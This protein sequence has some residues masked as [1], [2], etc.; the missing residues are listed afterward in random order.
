MI[1]IY[2]NNIENV[3]PSQSPP[4]QPPPSQSPPSQSSPSQSPPSQSP[5]SQPP[6]SQPPP[7]Q[8]PPLQSPPHSTSSDIQ[9]STIQTD[10]PTYFTHILSKE[11]ETDLSS[12]KRRLQSIISDLQITVDQC[13][14]VSTLQ[15][16]RTHLQSAATMGRAM[17]EH[18]S[19]TSLGVKRKIAS[20]K[21]QEKQLHFFST[22]KR[23]VCGT[24]GLSKPSLAE[25]SAQ[26][27]KLKKQE[28]KFCGVCLKENDTNSGIIDWIQCYVCTVWI[29]TSCSE[30]DTSTQDYVCQFCQ[31]T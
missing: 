28:A 4:S 7:S 19:D 14:N 22:K 20:T 31:K 1:E 30:T 2:H 10:T 6:P 12:L 9:H 15:A 11:K 27:N 3:E 25:M 5:P 26:K 17:N 23:K 13:V 16:M 8:S 21:H 29:H 24:Q 18:S